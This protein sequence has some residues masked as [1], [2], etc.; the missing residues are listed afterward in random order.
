MDTKYKK[1]SWVEVAVGD[2]VFLDDHE[3][4]LCPDADPGVSGPFVVVDPDTRTLSDR[5]SPRRPVVFLHY[6]TNLLVLEEGG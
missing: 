3:G 4:G 5:R 6:P 2:V 1:V